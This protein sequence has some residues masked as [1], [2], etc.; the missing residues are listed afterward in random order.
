MNEDI[1]A[2]RIMALSGEAEGQ[3]IPEKVGGMAMKFFT[4]RR[5]EAF[6]EGRERFNAEALKNAVKASSFV[7]AAEAFRPNA[8]KNE[9]AKK[10][11]VD[12]TRRADIVTF[13]QVDEEGNAAAR[14]LNLTTFAAEAFAVNRYTREQ[15]AALEEAL[16]AFDFFLKKNAAAEE[17][18][19]T[20]EG[21]KA[22]AE[23]FTK[24]CAACGLNTITKTAEGYDFF[25]HRSF[26]LVCA[27]R[28]RSRR[29]VFE[30]PNATREAAAAAVAAAANDK[31]TRA[32]ERAKKAEAAAVKSVFNIVSEAL[33][34]PE[35]Q[36][37]AAAAV[38]AAFIMRFFVARRTQKVYTF[39]N[40]GSDGR[41][42]EEQKEKYA[43][44][45]ENNTTQY[46]LRF[47]NNSGVPEAVKNA[48]QQTGETQSEYMKKAIVERLKSEGFLCGEVVLNQNKERHKAKIEKLAKY[49]EQEKAKM[50]K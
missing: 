36:K 24:L 27:A 18:A 44:W 47:L 12:Y 33:K 19:N 14:V 45:R 22:A 43:L 46:N 8:P 17:G 6:A 49:I 10:N 26:L 13:I 29:G 38:A 11:G 4:P 5:Y 39:S 2:G 30:T 15:A 40:E 21:L 37:Q 28:M 3:G 9:G 34:K 20:H 1:R 7:S 32:E 48:T 35:E 23:A 41:L 31:R 25:V 50:K 16:T 42:K